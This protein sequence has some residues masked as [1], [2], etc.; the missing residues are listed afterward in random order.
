[1]TL[2]GRPRV[3]ER[4][5]GL[6]HARPGATHRRHRSACSRATSPTAWAWARPTSWRPGSLDS[7]VPGTTSAERP[8]RIRSTSVVPGIGPRYI[9]CGTGPC[10]SLIGR[11]VPFH[12][13]RAAVRRLRPRRHHHAERAGADE[14][15]LRTDARQEL[16]RRLV[17]ADRDPEV[18][19]I[20]LTGA[21]RAF[22]AGLDL[23]A[24]SGAAGSAVGASPGEFEL[25]DAPPIVLHNVDTPTI[26]ALNGGAAGYGMDL[27]LGCDIR[28]AGESGKLAP[29]FTKRG[30]LPE[31]GG[32]WLL[33]RLVGYAKAA[34]IAFTGRTLSAKECLDLGLV[35]RSCPTHELPDGGAGPGQRDRRQRTAGRSGHQAHDA[36]GRDRDVRAERASRL[37]AAASAL[38]QR[39]L[40]G[41]HGGVPREAPRRLQGPLGPDRS[42]R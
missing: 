26:C 16:S 37:P 21:G 13:E 20:V 30:V 35:N 1:M 34:E 19:A 4:P 25:R 36:H 15:D 2:T 28:V 31:S 24:Q 8:W 11:T 18:R 12:H 23:R 29:A 33:P 6:D 7:G 32:T 38:P 22:C 39:G 14:H 5:R 41:G 40:Q 27:A 9:S 17:E 42:S 3:G 10:C